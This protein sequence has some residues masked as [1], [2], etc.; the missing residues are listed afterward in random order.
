MFTEASGD[1][2]ACVVI[3]DYY[4]NAYKIALYISQFLDI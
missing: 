1:I 3:S 2:Y 4:H